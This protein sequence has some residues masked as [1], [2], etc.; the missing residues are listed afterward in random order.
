MGVAQRTHN[1]YDVLVGVTEG[2]ITATKA[3]A[4]TVTNVN[5]APAVT[6]AGSASVAENSTAVMTVTASDPDAGTTLTYAIAGGADA[7]LFAVDPATGALSFAAPP[8]FEAPGDA[9]GDGV[10][11]VI[12]LVY[13][14]ALTAA[15]A[16]AVTVTNVHEPPVAAN[17][18]AATT[19]NAALHGSVAGNDSSPE[20]RPLTF[21]KLTDPGHGTVTVN[22]DGAYVYLPAAN[23]TGSDSFAYQVSDGQ[24]GTDSATVVI[25]V[26]SADPAPVASPDPAP[27]T[28]ESGDSSAS[29]S[30]L[31]S[32]LARGGEDSWQSWDVGDTP[33]EEDAVWTV[34]APVDMTN[35]VGHDNISGA[36]MMGEARR[37]ASVRNSASA[38]P[39]Q[40]ETEVSGRH[41]ILQVRE[42]S[43]GKASHH[44]FTVLQADGRPLPRW[45]SVLPN[46]CI[47][48]DL[49]EGADRLDLKIIVH[50]A[51]E[52]GTE[53]Y[54]AVQ[55]PG[56]EI[57]LAAKQ[58]QPEQRAFKFLDQL[59]RSRLERSPPPPLPGRLA[60]SSSHP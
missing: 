49:P 7:A 21:S 17:D 54:V 14:G 9:G 36:S 16:V 25:T 20:A 58:A 60:D 39:L 40:V 53:A 41:V 6:S 19:A 46:G 8:N 18:A 26:R 22:A 24:G 48:A 1:V 28:G 45:V 47:V 51:D 52:P 3:V 27:V 13:D 57:V 50:S 23:F 12:V 30:G 15:K 29:A 56:G 11:D 33:F 10:Y 35:P 34:D 37:V 38:P 31:A 2:A 4:V 32:Y 42:S 44:D 59:K 5:E 43:T 55:L